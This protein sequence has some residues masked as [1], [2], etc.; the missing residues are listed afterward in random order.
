MS[1][2]PSFPSVEHQR[3]GSVS[4]ISHSPK[5]CRC[6]ST[7]VLMLEE[8]EVKIDIIDTLAPDTALAFHKKIL[9]QSKA[10]LCCTQ[11]TSRSE[12]RMLLAFVCKKLGTLCERIVTRHI[13]PMRQEHRETPK[14]QKDPTAQ[15]SEAFSNGNQHEAYLGNYEIDLPYELDCLIRVLIVLQLRG[16]KALLAKMNVVATNG[17]YR[18]VLFA[19]ERKIDNVAVKLH[20][21]GIRS[22]VDT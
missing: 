3:K 5:M 1:L 16:L 10:M 9:S 15:E 4:L 8:L 19:A 2:G 11:C 6:Q 18:S 13:Y 20:Q 17:A 21:C 12:N 22:C 14:Q 7:A